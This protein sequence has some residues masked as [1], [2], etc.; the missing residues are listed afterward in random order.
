MDLEAE[1][2]CPGCGKKFKQKIKEMVPGRSRTCPH[3]RVN[4]E[5][6]GDDARKAQKAL[7]DFQKSLKKLGRR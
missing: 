2:T 6:S 7:D 1:V 5:F 3:C 4:I